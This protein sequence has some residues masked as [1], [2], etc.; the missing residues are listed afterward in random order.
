[1]AGSGADEINRVAQLIADRLGATEPGQ[2]AVIW[3]SVRALGL[4]GALG[5]L[6]EAVGVA[7]PGRS[8]LEAY[9][10]MARGRMP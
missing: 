10:G 1:M 2:I 5:L 4:G 8:A 3:R 7:A 9:L 6:D